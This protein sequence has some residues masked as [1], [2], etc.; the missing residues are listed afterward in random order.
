MSAINRPLSPHLSAYGW[1]ITMLTSILHR[2]SGVAL[3]GG[4]V[5]FTAWLLAL[6]GGASDYQ[7]FA[8]LASS[9]VG[10]VILMLIS[11]AVFY[12]LANGVRH[13]VWDAGHGFDQQTAT[14]SAWFVVLVSLAATAAFWALVYFA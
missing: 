10:Q 11:L 12:H 8:A 14:R 4:A 3:A 5:V 9:V 13:L 2:A 6:A 7:A 1:R